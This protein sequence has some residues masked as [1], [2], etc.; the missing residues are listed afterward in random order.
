[1]EEKGFVTKRVAELLRKKGFDCKVGH[2]YADDYEIS[3]DIDE[4]LELYM[5]KWCYEWGKTEYEIEE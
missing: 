3:E 5:G 1:M 4:C 2:Y